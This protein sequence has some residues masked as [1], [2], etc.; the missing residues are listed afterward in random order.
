MTIYFGTVQYFGQN[1]SLTI[2]LGFK[3]WF[4]DNK[5]EKDFIFIHFPVGILAEPWEH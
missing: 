3:G 1:S 5:S 2:I 4:P